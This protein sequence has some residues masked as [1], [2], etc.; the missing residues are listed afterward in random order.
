MVCGDGASKCPAGTRLVTYS[1]ATGDY[2]AGIKAS[3]LLPQWAISRIDGG[4][5]IAGSG[6]S[7]EVK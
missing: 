4:G 6:Y 1:E 7:Y 3:G 2:N 5:S